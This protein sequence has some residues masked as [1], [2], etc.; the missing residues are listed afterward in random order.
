MAYHTDANHQ[1]M[2]QITEIKQENSTVKTL[3]FDDENCQRAT[4]GQFVMVWIPC[5]DEVPMSISCTSPN[6][7]SISIEKVGQATEA[8]HQMRVGDLIGI[9][10]PFGN[11]FTITKKGN[12][13]IV[14]G[15]TG[16][17]PLKFL[18][19]KLAKSTAKMTFL[20]GAKTKDE[21]LFQ[22]RIEPLIR[23]TLGKLVVTTDDGSCGL[24]CRITEP[25]EDLLAKERFD[26]IYTCGP[27]PMM[28]KML[29]LAEQHNVPLQASLERLMRCAIGICGSC[30]IGGFR[31]CADGPVF[32]KEQLQTVR[33]E[34]GRFRLDFAGRKRRI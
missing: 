34:F 23:K 32:T 16:L 1:R 22:N 13:L 12:V 11:G 19:E 7:V 2:V 30:V 3:G 4:P 28:V 6:S 25:V 17:I 24:K 20:A 29:L 15:G 9:R 31:V 18:A 5:L 26:M 10:G 14:G 8:L 21:M 27:E 33:D